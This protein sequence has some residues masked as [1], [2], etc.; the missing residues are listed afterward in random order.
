VEPLLESATEVPKALEV[1]GPVNCG[2]VDHEEP[3]PVN[4]VAAPWPAAPPP[5]SPTSAVEPSLESATEVP[6]ELAVSGAVSAVP[7]D[8][9]VPL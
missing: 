3:P 2:P 4:M 6:N 7:A 1:F 9:E 8:H 5:G